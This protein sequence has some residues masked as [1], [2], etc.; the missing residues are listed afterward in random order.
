M[1]ARPEDK[2]VLVVEDD[3]GMLEYFSRIVRDE[4]FRVDT[5][6]DGIKTVEKMRLRNPDVVLLD[7]ML[8]RYGGLELLL[9]LR[10]GRAA[11]IPLIIVTA[12]YTDPASA[13]AILAHPS[14]AGFFVKP[15]KPEL[16]LAALHK[17]L[18]TGPPA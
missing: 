7:L 17:T 6:M 15:V 3:P 12:R 18:G 4:G 9:E 13:D 2:L 16:L 10:R 14:V 8:P 5:A 1:A 11:A